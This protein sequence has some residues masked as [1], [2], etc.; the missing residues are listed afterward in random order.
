MK[1][2]WKAPMSFRAQRSRT[3]TSA[4]TPRVAGVSR[5][6][7][8]ALSTIEKADGFAFVG[9]RLHPHFHPVIFLLTGHAFLGYWNDEDRRDEFLTTKDEPLLST[10]EEPTRYLPSRNNGKR[11]AS[12]LCLSPSLL[13]Q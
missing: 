7:R 13:S 4:A 6:R 11:K 5:D 12:E 9:K 1:P 10:Q 3:T 8:G 2:P